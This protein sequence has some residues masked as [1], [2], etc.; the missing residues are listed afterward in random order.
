MKWPII[1]AAGNPVFS[2]WSSTDPSQNEVIL[3]SSESDF[4]PAARP[5]ST[6][7]IP[8]IPRVLQS[9]HVIST[10]GRLSESE[11]V[12]SSI[13]ENLNPDVPEFI[14][15]ELT[16]KNNESV[17][18]DSGS[19][20]TKNGKRSDPAKTIPA[21]SLNNGSSSPAKDAAFKTDDTSSAVVKSSSPSRA[22]GVK[23]N[24]ELQMLSDDVWKEVIS[25]S[26]AYQ[27][28]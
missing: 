28:H 24:G 6:I 19:D 25:F 20:S 14:P 7:P 5:L 3:S 23:V 13:G 12:S 17:A 2:E 1:D 18:A 26:W 4:F 9:N 10:V 16:N 22:P 15:N 11:S 27:Y 21:A 8:P